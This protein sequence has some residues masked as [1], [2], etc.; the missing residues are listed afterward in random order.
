GKPTELESRFR[1]TYSMILNLLRV[2]ALRVEDM[3]KR[4]FSE[5]HMQKNAKVNEKNLEELSEKM[6]QLKE[7]Q[8]SQCRSDLQEYYVTCKEIHSLRHSLQKLIVTNPHAA[9]ALTPGR[10]LVI[11]YGNLRNLLAVLLSVSGSSST[12]R[13]FTV[14]I[15]TD[16]NA[17]SPISQSVSNATMP[18]TP[19]S[20]RLY[21]PEGTCGHTVVEVK[22]E[23]ISV[24][25]TRTM[26]VSGDK[27]IEDYKKRQ[28]P[29][30][31]DAPPGPSCS[32]ATQELLRL[33]ESNPDGMEAMDPVTDFQ[34]R[35]IDIVEQFY[36]KKMME[37]SISKYKCLNCSQFE[38][39][40]NLMHENMKIKDK[41]H[42]LKYL[43]SDQSLQLLP[44]YEQRINVLR[45]LRYIDDSNTVQLKGRV[46]C[47]ISNH[48]LIITELVF[49]NIL[50]SLHPNEI[51]A[52]LSCMVFQERRCSEPELTETLEKGQEQIVS[53]ATRIGELQKQCGLTEPVEDYV[54]QFK[55]GLTEVVYEWGRGMPFSEITD[56]TD[57]QEGI[58]VRTIQ[59]LNEVCIDVRNAARI[60]GDPTLYQ[61]MEEASNG[62]KRD[63][64][65][66]AS[67]YTQ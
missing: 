13:T 62:I 28:I 17:D 21:H 24:I 14:L 64:V 5:F 6:K 30:F 2:E 51:A 46:A 34:I 20:K 52:L 32:S 36:Q 22:G 41:F 3:M 8:C 31:R 29:R 58:I 57:V 1:L 59:R 35:D 45:S 25:T 42:H 10:I 60:V 65:F 48:E 39:H 33:I 26:K 15:I 12:V 44:E 23:N 56:L 55:F 16:A 11:N 38:Q 50:T 37:N 7:I 61:K 9:K 18:I 66:A 19:T 47:E 43:L 40:F 53:V 63:I 49:E 4:S 27:V 54:A 67:L